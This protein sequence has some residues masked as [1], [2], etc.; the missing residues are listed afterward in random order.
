VNEPIVGEPTPAALGGP[1]HEEGKP[2]PA[3]ARTA[4]FAC[5]DV[6]ARRTTVVLFDHTSDIYLAAFSP[7]GRILAS[8]SASGDKT[9]QLW[10]PS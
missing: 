5:V 10:C 9:V 3:A 8:A 7:H 6:A 4:P 2:W 1:R